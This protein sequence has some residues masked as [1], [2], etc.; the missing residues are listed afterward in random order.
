MLDK[1]QL[2]AA[3]PDIERVDLPELGPDAF[4]FV[5]GLTGAERD[6]FETSM[7]KDDGTG[8]DPAR[9][10]NIRARIAV[11]TACDETGERIFASAD[12]KD[13]TAMRADV[14]DRITAT[15]QRLSGM[16]PAAVD[17]LGKDSASEANGSSGIN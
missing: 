1:T 7:L 13:V 11:L 15:A 16:A 4:V 14:L 3:K 5:R 6:L 12:L 9:R 10:G 2:L 8:L 17:Q